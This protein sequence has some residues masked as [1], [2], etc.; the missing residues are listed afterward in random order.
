MKP[1]QTLQGLIKQSK[2]SLVK[3][4]PM[5]LTSVG[6]VGVVATA[7]LT[8][9]GTIR[10]CELLNEE[11]A[12][13]NSESLSK[14]EIVHIAWHCYIPATTAL[15]TTLA[16]IFGANVMSK[17]NQASMVSAYAMLSQSYQ[18]YRR[19][20]KTVYGEDADRKI[21]A[22]MAE[23]RYIYDQ[24]NGSV[25]YDP[26]HDKAEIEL[27]YD[28]FSGRY[29]QSTLLAVINAQYHLNR[30]Y[31]LG[32]SITVNDFYH[33]LGIDKIDGGD[34]VGWCSDELYESNIFWIDFE[35]QFTKLAGGMECYIVSALYEPHPIPEDIW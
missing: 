27:F 17:R 16:C 34:A 33:F 35:N 28:H 25:L 6:A 26:D 8:A 10:A 3:A 29:F 31:A 18:N 9:K 13:S 4:S 14:G 24:S 20:A 11:K 19:A 30:N 15:L 22:Q 2:T 23:E 32:G 12:S 7:V 21:Q 5:I 1:K